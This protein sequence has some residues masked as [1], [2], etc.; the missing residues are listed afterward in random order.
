MKWCEELSSYF[1]KPDEKICGNTSGF[2]TVKGSGSLPI[3]L[4]KNRL[5]LLAANLKDIYDK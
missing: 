5:D 2:K 3:K 1:L 4:S